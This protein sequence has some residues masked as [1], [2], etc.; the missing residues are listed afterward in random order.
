M[1][2]IGDRIRNRRKELGLTQSSLGKRI[3]IS[4]PAISQLEK[5]ESK[6]PSS[7]NLLAL[8]NALN[9]S[10]NWLQSG[11]DTPTS[12]ASVEFEQIPVLNVEL[13]A[14][15]GSYIDSENIIDWVP[16]SQDWIYDNHLAKKDLA[17]VKVSGD[18]MIPRLQD[19]DML[20]INTAENQTVSGNIY[21]IEVDG[22]L[23]V[24]RLMKKMD[25]SWAIS[26]DNK[27]DPAYQDE[28][29]SHHNLEQ[30]RVIGRAVR[31]LMGKL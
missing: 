31:V 1:Q 10:P 19:G 3:G 24:K 26:S 15:V 5:G 29:I 6:A 21:A 28:I 4:A 8:A 27:S 30:L 12:T 16:I 25:G 13:S 14:G 22:E 11:I 2:T 7:E 23:R 18:S 20:L 9:C 17:I